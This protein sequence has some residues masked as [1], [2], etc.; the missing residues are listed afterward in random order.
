MIQVGAYEAKTHLS[1]LL[2][3]VREGEQVVITKHNV[4]IAKLVPADYAPGQDTADTIAQIRQ[5]RVGKRLRGVQLRE[6]IEEGR[7]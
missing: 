7:R 6:M 3:Q 4:P 5:F 2:E 1:R